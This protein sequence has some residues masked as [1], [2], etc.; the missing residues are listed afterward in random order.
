MGKKLD[1]KNKERLKDY[2]TYVL[3]ALIEL[4]KACIKAKMPFFVS[5]CVDEELVNE[6]EQR[7]EPKYVYAGFRNDMLSPFVLKEDIKPNLFAEFV[8]VLNGYKTVLPSEHEEQMFSALNIED[9]EDY[10]K[11]INK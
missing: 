9:P 5:V 10:M 11:D 8:K 6:E 3:P 1:I 2:N 7:N 4:K